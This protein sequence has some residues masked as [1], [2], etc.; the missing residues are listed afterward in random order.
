MSKILNISE[1]A[2][3]ALHSM[4]LIAKSEEILNVNKIADITKFSKSHLAKVMHQLVK[5]NFLKSSRGPEG[6]YILAKK[7]EEISLLEIYRIIEGDISTEGCSNHE[8]CLFSMC[9]FGG[10]NTKFANEFSEFLKSNTLYN[11]IN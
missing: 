11:I 8:N 7:P 2:S 1:A 6:G 4:A 9:V 3:I 10:L 5:F